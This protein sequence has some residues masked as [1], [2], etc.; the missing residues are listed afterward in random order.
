VE[1]RDQE[2]H[3]IN[4]YFMIYM[5]ATII[6]ILAAIHLGVNRVLE[7]FEKAK[8]EDLIEAIVDKYFLEFDEDDPKIANTECS[9]CQLEFTT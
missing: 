1:F 2:L 3:L 7:R 5:Y 9:I 8:Y 6:G 4:F